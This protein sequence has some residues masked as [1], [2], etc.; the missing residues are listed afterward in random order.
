MRPHA[1]LAL[2]LALSGSACRDEDP[3]PAGESGEESTGAQGPACFA[4]EAQQ[5]CV[6]ES[7]SAELE[8]CWGADFA[9]GDYAGPCQAPL[10]CMR[11]CA[12]DDDACEM[13]CFADAEVACLSCTTTLRQCEQSMC[14]TADVCG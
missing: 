1:A 2:L 5:S 9:A 11:A 8:A 13:A 3:T 12:C 6:L 4:C 7:C 14:A 10:E